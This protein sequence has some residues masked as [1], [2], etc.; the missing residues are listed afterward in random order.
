MLPKWLSNGS[1]DGSI[2]VLQITA[3]ARLV[4]HARYRPDTLGRDLCDATVCVLAAIKRLHQDTADSRLA[5]ALG[6]VLASL[7]ALMPHE[8][9]HNPGAEPP[10]PGVILVRA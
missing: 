5:H 7:I 2:V 3:A 8:D 4:S 1:P 9:R 6:G 10:P